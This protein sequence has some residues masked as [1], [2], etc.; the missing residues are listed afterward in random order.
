MEEPVG[1][2]NHG[3]SYQLGLSWPILGEALLKLSYLAQEATH[4][5]E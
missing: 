4:A 3:Y 1:T 5:P 2:I